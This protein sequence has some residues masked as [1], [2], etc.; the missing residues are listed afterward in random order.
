MS[1]INLLPENLREEEEKEL[2]AKPS[3]AV[4]TY[5]LSKQEDKSAGQTAVSSLDSVKEVPRAVFNNLKES[6][7]EVKT[8]PKFLSPATDSKKGVTFWQKF[9]KRKGKIIVQ[10]QKSITSESN[11][12]FL[13]DIKDQTAANQKEN[14]ALKQAFVQSAPKSTI[15]GKEI[16]VNFLPEGMNLLPLKKLRFYFGLSAIICVIILALGYF[17]INLANQFLEKQSQ[18]INQQLEEAEASYA[19]LIAKE[20]EA[21]KWSKRVAVISSL[22]ENHVYWTKFFQYLEKTTIPD[23]YYTNIGISSDGLVTLTGQATNYT[24]VARQYQVFLNNSE[25]FPK[26]TLGG[27]SG[28][29]QGKGGV[30]FNVQLKLAT[31]TYYSLETQ[32]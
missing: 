14:P 32:K 17:G 5:H 1:D 26:V 16:D 3:A 24:T 20:E 23:V 4:R 21:A 28:G 18:E 10:P 7:G 29:D 2:A 13:K 9:F 6:S 11:Q 30:G 19:K 25:I 12:L 31:Q 27:F 8:L 22:L 15:F